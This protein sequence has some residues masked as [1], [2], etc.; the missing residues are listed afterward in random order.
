VVVSTD[1]A[2]AMSGARLGLQARLK[3]INLSIIWHHCC[4]H[5]EALASK[6]IPKKL[7]EVLRDIVQDVNLIKDR[8]LN[9]RI[10]NY[11]M[12]IW[13]AYTSS[14][15]YTLKYAGYREVKLCHVFLN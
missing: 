12:K 8:S 4:I 11:I 5:R 1:R 13:E 9:Y 6:N 15:Y 3:T 10:F 14:C 7:N 2:H